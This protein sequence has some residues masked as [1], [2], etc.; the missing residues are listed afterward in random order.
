MVCEHCYRHGSKFSEDDWFF[1]CSKCEQVDLCMECMLKL[2]PMDDR[3]ED[4]ADT[5][6]RYCQ[7]DGHWI[8][9]EIDID[10]AISELSHKDQEDKGKSTDTKPHSGV[11]PI[12]EEEEEADND[13]FDSNDKNSQA[14]DPSIVLNAKQ[15]N[16][17]KSCIFF[18]I[19]KNIYLFE[20]FDRDDDGLLQNA[21]IEEMW[22]ASQYQLNRDKFKAPLDF[23]EFQD[24][25][26]QVPTKIAEAI[27]QFL[28]KKQKQVC[29]NHITHLNIYSPKNSHRQSVVFLERVRDIFEY[30]DRNMDGILAVDDINRMLP[31]VNVTFGA[32]Q[33]KKWFEPPCDFIKFLSRLQTMEEDLSREVLDRLV[34]HIQLRV[35][36][37]FHFFTSE[38]HQDMS[39]EAFSQM[40]MFSLKKETQ[41]QK[42]YRFPCSEVDF[43]DNWRHLGVFEQHG[44]LAEADKR[45][46]KEVIV[47]KKNNF[48]L[49]SLHCVACLCVI[50]YFIFKQLRQVFNFYDIDNGRL[51]R[52][53]CQELLQAVGGDP[54][55]VN[56][57]F[58]PPCS[59]DRFLFG[60][61]LLQRP[62]S[63]DIV[64]ALQKHVQEVATSFFVLIFAKKKTTHTQH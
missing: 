1:Q 10:D 52:E 58:S 12:A 44:I 34:H 59:F 26:K 60:W 47:E 23:R 64:P 30:F 63:T 25:W 6:A 7:V 49:S 16:M 24:A 5:R 21:D 29:A 17:K 32:D 42:Y 37:V 35:K 61:N 27:W 33:G 4:D 22:S 53:V 2:R 50:C 39:E 43:I 19:R 15:I 41:W 55:Q 54:N 14:F 46:M 3:T 51:S 38:T 18:F 48:V 45:L 9:E 57:L 40:Y 11:E 62:L 28:E 8:F 13:E 20:F 31:L 36:D 56:I